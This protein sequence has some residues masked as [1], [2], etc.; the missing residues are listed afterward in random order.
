M[1][2]EKSQTK[3][4]KRSLEDFEHR[5]TV[6]LKENHYI[7]YALSHSK[8]Q[9]QKG[10]KRAVLWAVLFTVL[11]LIALYKGSVSGSKWSDIYLTMGV[12]FIVFQIFNLFYNFVMFPIALKRS[13][14]KELKKDPSLLAPMEYAFKPDK[15]VCFLESKHRNTILTEDISGV[16]ETQ[17]T[18]I[19]QIK[20]GRRVIFPK[21]T[22]RGADPVIVQQIDSLRKQG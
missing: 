10:K 12:L 13:I 20:S 17:D 9:I 14:L 16:E 3:Q 22:L 1:K 7:D 8:E 21:E 6:Q 4:E 18:M 11:G 2:N 5:I 19:L 15:I